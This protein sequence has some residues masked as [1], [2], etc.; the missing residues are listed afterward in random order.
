MPE[1]V[2]DQATPETKQ[3]FSSY[4]ESR[5]APVNGAVDPVHGQPVEDSSAGTQEPEEHVDAAPETP[6]NA[7]DSEPVKQGKA[8]K[9]KAEIQRDIDRLTRERYDA[10]RAL[11]AAR[12]GQQPQAQSNPQ[13]QPVAQSGTFDGTDQNDPKPINSDPKYQTADG[14][15]R[16]QEDLNRWG[17]RAEWRRMQ[18]EQWHA[19]AQEQARVQN[20]AAQEHWKRDHD[21]FE[22]RGT[23]YAADHPEYPELVEKLKS[24]PLGDEIALPLMR[25]ENG[26]QMLHHLMANQDELKRIQNLPS[27]I[28]RLEAM[29]ELKYRLQYPDAFKPKSPANPKPVSNARPAGSQLRGA[30]GGSSGSEP[31]SFTD[32]R[33]KRF[34]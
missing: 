17:A 33:N 24:Q 19:Q 21:A 7:T 27:V 10:E 22:E 25:S 32:Y 14:W 3:T 11:Q 26:P 5:G 4:R 18:R 8:D 2:L 16:Y 15:A 13:G 12:Q 28:E 1:A 20:E 30:S 34:G 6:E 23:A 31:K 9:R 29:Y